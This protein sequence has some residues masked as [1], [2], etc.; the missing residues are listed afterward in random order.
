LKILHFSDPPLGTEWVDLISNFP[1]DDK[2][3]MIYQIA[4]Y[5]GTLPVFASVVQKDPSAKKELINPIFQAYAGTSDPA[6]RE[7]ISIMAHT[8]DPRFK[9]LIAFV[10]DPSNE[11]KRAAYQRS[12]R[13]LVMAG[14][15]PVVGVKTLNLGSLNLT[16]VELIRALDK[17]GIMP[18]DEQGSFQMEVVVKYF[19]TYPEK[20]KKIIELILK[21]TPYQKDLVVNTL[22]SR[23]ES[24][25]RRSLDGTDE[26]NLTTIH[27]KVE[28]E[29]L[30]NLTARL[31]ETY[32]LKVY[33]QFWK[34]GEKLRRSEK[35]LKNVGK[36]IAL[37]REL[38]GF[39]NLL[40]KRRAASARGQ[41]YE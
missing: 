24:S 25:Y 37:K 36:K 32:E 33:V 12:Y 22:L 30:K 19:A 29:I 9:D 3:E 23:I 10:S 1:P 17:Q 39:K 7:S 35:A 26:F 34:A 31:S 20:G 16:R 40:K 2:V 41:R 18:T 14:V 15:G 21:S 4:N 8:I 28:L 27:P 11:A 13:E 38:K 6:I 5:A